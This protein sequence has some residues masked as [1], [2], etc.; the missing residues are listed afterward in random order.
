MIGIKLLLNSALL[1]FQNILILA[2]IHEVWYHYKL[3][4][5]SVYGMSKLSDGLSFLHTSVF[6]F[7][8]HFF[9]FSNTQPIISWK[10]VK[11]HRQTLQNQLRCHTMRHLI[12]VYIV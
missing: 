5:N 7:F 4:L 2:T 12:R 1:K 9:I 3:I 8:I 11:N 10:P 6:S